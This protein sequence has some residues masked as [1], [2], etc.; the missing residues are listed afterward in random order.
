MSIFSKIFQK[1][2]N[3]DEDNQKKIEDRVKS[4]KDR[5]E[6]N[7]ELNFKNY[8]EDPNY[9]YGE[10]IEEEENNDDANYRDKDKE[11][12]KEAKLEYINKVKKQAQKEIEKK[13]KN[14]VKTGDDVYGVRTSERNLHREVGGM[15]LDYELMDKVE[16][17]KGQMKKKLYKKLS[18]RALI[19]IKTA[20]AMRSLASFGLSVL[21]KKLTLIKVKKM[22]KGLLTKSQIKAI[23]N[24]RN[25]N[26]KKLKKV[27]AKIVMITKQTKR[28]VK[29]ISREKTFV[30]KL[31]EKAALK[32]NQKKEIKDV[33]RGL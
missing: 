5:L 15:E 32:K 7:V 13:K 27:R 14:S 31:D 22:F 3:E 2:L 8:A 29:Q 16:Q 6:K 12:A 21:K 10:E 28:Q 25:V 23:A 30:E 18:T 1:L 17:F 24:G 20:K 33:I 26:I 11:R 9:M 19:K 4:F